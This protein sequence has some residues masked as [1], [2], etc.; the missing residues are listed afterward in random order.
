MYAKGVYKTVTTDELEHYT[1]KGWQLIQVLHQRMTLE[2]SVS[3]PNPHYT[4]I[5]A[6]AQDAALAGQSPPYY[7]GYVPE[8]IDIIVP[9]NTVEIHF[10]LFRDEKSELAVAVKEAQRANTL[11]LEHLDRAREAEKNELRSS[12][13]LQEN[14][15][16]LARVQR[17]QGEASEAHGAVLEKLDLANGEL[18]AAKKQVEE[19]EKEL[20]NHHDRFAGI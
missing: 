11:A 2:N 1:S 9:Y 13:L 20:A 3:R 19:L 18:L 10:L 6:G 12:Q 8:H 17:A 14:K 4:A 7:D 16:L 5:V 15:D